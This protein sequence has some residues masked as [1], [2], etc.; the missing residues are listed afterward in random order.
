MTMPLSLAGGRL[1]ASGSADNAV[2]YSHGRR[3]GCATRLKGRS[4]VSLYGFAPFPI[5][6]NISIPTADP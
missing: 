4:I 1:T 2:R 5:V 6:V 3:A